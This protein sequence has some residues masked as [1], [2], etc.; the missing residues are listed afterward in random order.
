MMC[1][2]Y[3]YLYSLPV[4]LGMSLPTTELRLNFKQKVLCYLLLKDLEIW[5][6]KI[7]YLHDF[8]LSLYVS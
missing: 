2:L 1:Q 4:Y 6:E 3:Q 5:K 7:H 8:F